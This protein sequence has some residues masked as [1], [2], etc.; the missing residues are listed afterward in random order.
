RRFRADV[1]IRGDR[2][3]Q[4]GHLPDAGAGQVID[5]SGKVVAPGFVDVHNHSDAWLRKTPHLVSKTMQGFTTEVIMADGISYAPV[6]PYNIHDWITYLRALNALRFEEYTGWTSLAEYMAGLDR[7]NVQNSIAH[8]PYANVRTL[9]LGFG[10]ETPDDYQRRQIIAE[11]EKGMEAGAVGLSTGLDYVAQWFASTEEL[12][13]ACRPLAASQG[14]YVTHMRYKRGTLWALKEAVEIGKRAGVPVHISHLKGTSPALTEQIITYIDT[15]AVN[16]VD[17]SFDVY[18]YLPGS[19]MLNYWLPYSVYEQGPLNVLPH[20]RRPEVRAQMGENLRHVALDQTHIAWLPG[21]ENSRHQGQLVSDY[22]AE[23]GLPAPEALCNLLIEENLGVLLVMHQGDDD[24]IGPFLAHDRYMMGSDG[25]YHEDGAIHP[26]Q[27]G[28]AAR[29]L[30]PAVRDKG[31]LT[32]EDAVYKLSGFPARRFGLTQRGELREGWYADV[33]V[34]DP[35]TITDR[36]TYRDPHQLAV[37]VEH[38]LVNGAAIIAG[39]QPVT[40]LPSPLPGRALKFKQP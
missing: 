3:V 14:L 6:S 36:A 2:I 10:R 31:W 29:L 30:G 15:V 28:S 35:D 17:F 27:Y 38:V 8:V 19:T 5:A 39:G 26:R 25:I 24:L 20:L 13:E 22:V 18:P 40:E 4:I 23:T 21:K 12:V 33:V 11:V 9:A 37:G 34:F 7:A 32:L 1:G 16:E